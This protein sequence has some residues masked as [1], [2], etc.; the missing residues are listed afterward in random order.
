M[1]RNAVF[2]FKLLLFRKIF[3]D[4]NDRSLREYKI[5]SEMYDYVFLDFVIYLDDV[6]KDSP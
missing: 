6:R 5:L 4:K 3:N 1:M 2:T